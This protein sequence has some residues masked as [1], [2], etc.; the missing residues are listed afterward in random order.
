[1]KTFLI[2]FV[3]TILTDRVAPEKPPSEWASVRYYQSEVNTEFTMRRIPIEELINQ[4]YGRLT[5]ISEAE[6]HR[7][8]NNSTV[9]MFNCKCECGNETI[10][11]LDNLIKRH[12]QSCGCYRRDKIKEMFST[13]KKSYTSLYKVWAGMKRRCTN[14]KQ[15]RFKNYGGRGIKIC[16]EWLNDPKNFYDW[17]MTNGYEK[18]LT[19]D[20]EN[21]N[22]NYEP[23][24]CKWI[25]AKMNGRKT[26]STKLTIELA[27]EI[28]NLYSSGH[29]TQRE[30]AG[31]YRVAPS[32]ISHIITNRIWA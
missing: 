23:N 21:N 13:H 18:G 19:I 8:P 16:E 3:L 30:L 5:I 1:M 7:Q 15:N 11:G 25:T 32:T 17:A 26:S 2:I 12:T 22:G 14:P 28:R 29:T 4:R 20:R 24:N 27:Q 6:I 10:V 31:I 9:R